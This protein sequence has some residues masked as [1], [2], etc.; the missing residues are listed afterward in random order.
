M[1]EWCC[2]HDLPIHFGINLSLLQKSAGNKAP[3]TCVTDLCRA[4][5]FRA[6]LWGCFFSIRAVFC[7]FWMQSFPSVTR[8]VCVW[9]RDTWL[10]P[11]T[12]SEGSFCPSQNEG[13]L[14]PEVWAGVQ[15][16]PSGST[17]LQM[18]G[19]KAQC[20]FA[21]WW[22]EVKGTKE[23]LRVTEVWFLQSCCK[24]PLRVL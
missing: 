7:C 2:C 9:S 8:G 6:V 1:K 19:V 13:W 16:Q 12:S 18:G 23:M 15:A 10:V 24:A 4:G 20:C 11:V 5:Q 17:E 3:L 14:S 22:A 21:L